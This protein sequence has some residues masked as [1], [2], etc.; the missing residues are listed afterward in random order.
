MK[1]IKVLWFLIITVCPILFSVSLIASDENINNE[2]KSEWRFT[3]GAKAVNSAGISETNTYYKPEIRA[4]IYTEHISLYSGISRYFNYQI[5][6]GYGEYEYIDINEANAGLDLYP[7]EHLNLSFEYRYRDGE[8][9]Y[10]KKE[11]FSS[12]ELPFEKVSLIGDFS[13][14]TEEY[15]FADLPVKIKSNQYSFELDYFPFRRLDIDLSYTHS[16]IYF[17]N[18]DFDYY[19]RVV[20]LGIV[21]EL[22]D[23]FFLIGGLSMGKDSDD[24][25]IYGFDTGINWRI[26]KN[27]KIQALY[28]FTYYMAPSDSTE[29]TDSADAGKSKTSNLSAYANQS[30]KSSGPNQNNPPSGANQSNPFLEP[31]KI[32]ESYSSRKISLGISFIY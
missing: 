11:I 7:F 32:G 15:S 26:N 25:M 13:I 3:P 1:K 31:E 6:N 21:P 23:S 9:E 12:I 30:N 10:I 22:A 4:G 14:D 18:L 17:T 19:K 28:I 5:T 2:K 16:N 20:R 27:L 8:S 24:Y 29:G